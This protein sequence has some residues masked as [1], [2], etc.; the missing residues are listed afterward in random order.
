MKLIRF[1]I[2]AFVMMMSVQ[3]ANAQSV[4][5]SA[6]FGRPYYRVVYR[7][8]YYG[9]PVYYGRPYYRARYY[10][11]PVYYHRYYRAH[12]YYRHW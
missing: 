10:D 8:G 3:F 7:E 11:R 12:H 4:S 1:S 6:H 5:I 2:I 9:R